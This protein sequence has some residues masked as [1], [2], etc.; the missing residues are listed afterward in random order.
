MKRKPYSQYCRE[1]KPEAIRLAAAGD[2][3]ATGLLAS[4]EFE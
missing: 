3:S 1:F 4:W 2:K